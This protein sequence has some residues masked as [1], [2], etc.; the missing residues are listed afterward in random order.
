M[1]SNVGNI[2]V[3]LDNSIIR[4]SV[5]AQSIE[6]SKIV[7]FGDTEYVFPVEA[8]ERKP[9]ISPNQVWKIRQV[10]C[11][12]TIARLVHENK[13]K[14]YTYTELE[15]E[16]WSGERGIQGTFGDLFSN[17]TIAKVPPAIERSRFNAMDFEEC[18]SRDAVKEFCKFLFKRNVEELQNIPGLWESVTEFE[19][20]N[21]MQIDRFKLFLRKLNE[22]HFPDAFHLWT[23]EMN[24]INYFLTM[25]KKFINV[26]KNNPIEY[27][28]CVPVSPKM[29]LEHIG[30]DELDPMPTFNGGPQF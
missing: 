6:T 14:L 20:N 18:L 27:F 29:L 21:L 10:E 24:G 1:D 15:F 9:P 2:S 22:V 28:K 16:D 8:W 11:L 3:L 4:D 19:R 30:V 26:V 5:V 13:I 25:D 7:R 23:A 17:T 12:P